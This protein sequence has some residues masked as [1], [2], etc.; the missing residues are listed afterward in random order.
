M[1]ECNYLQAIEGGIDS[2]HVPFLHGVLD[3]VRRNS[4]QQKFLYGDTAPRLRVQRTEYGFAYG[5]ERNAEDD[6][7]YWRLTPFLFPFFTVI[8][9]FTIT[10]DQP[11]DTDPSSLTYSGHGWIPMDDENCWM[12]TYSW[13]ESRV[14][15]DDE[16]HP[17]HFLDLDPRSLQATVNA[18]N[19]YGID[20]EVQRTTT[21]TGIANGSIQD[22]A[23]QE[24][25]GAIFDRSKEHLGTSDGAI[26]HLRNMYLEG[27][28]TV[29]EGGEP[30]VPNIPDAFR[31][32]SVSAVLNRNVPFVEGLKYMAVE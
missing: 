25:M 8:P 30:F 5:A 20:R 22:A 3:P 1:Q 7:Y 31:V 26:I 17:A 16:G 2:S 13:N 27:V 24:T 29:L 10:Q 12:F 23:V 15:A 9:G 32:R 4:P 14:L 11:T 21:F 28:R 19:D 6:S 18:G